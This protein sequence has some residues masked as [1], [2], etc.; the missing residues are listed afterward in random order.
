M[1]TKK[2]GLKKFSIILLTFVLV[3]SLASVTLTFAENDSQNEAQGKLKVLEVPGLPEG[4]VQYNKTDVI[5]I[6]QEEKVQS[7]ESALFAYQNTTMLF[8]STMNCDLVITAE[9]NAYQ[10]IFALSVDPNQTMTL[11][12]NFGSD[13]LQSEQE[14]DKNLNFYANIEPNATLKL[15]AQLRLYINQTELS[16]ELGW[17][18]NPEKL[19]WMFWNGTQNQWIKVPSYIDP[20]GYLTCNTDHFSIWTVGEVVYP[21]E[22]TEGVTDMTLVYG[23]IVVGLVAVVALGIV[24]YRKRK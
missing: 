5:P 20:N 19:T 2:V 12:M 16:E 14:R 17:E 11:T 18:I 23:G 6:D 10:K 4:V 3:I 7:G 1:I 8:N 9:T 13:P 15:N 21:T 24:V 22:Q